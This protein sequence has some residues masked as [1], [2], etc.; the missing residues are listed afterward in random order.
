MQ[1]HKSQSAVLMPRN[2]MLHCSRSRH[3]DISNACT[4]KP[5]SLLRWHG[6]C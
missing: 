2:S 6:I 3:N 4:Y 5:A 1:S